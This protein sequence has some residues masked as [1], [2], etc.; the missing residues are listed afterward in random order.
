MTNAVKLHVTGRDGTS[1]EAGAS[2]KGT[3][4][5]VLR[6]AGDNE[7][8]ALC[9][10]NCS[11]GTC[12]VYIETAATLPEPGLEEREMLDT[13]VHQTPFSRLACQVAVNDGIELLRIRIAP[14]E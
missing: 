10:G 12:H 9:G 1:W 7:I 5:S 6:G 3:P 11:C 14:E 8:L 2:G 4:L 13:L